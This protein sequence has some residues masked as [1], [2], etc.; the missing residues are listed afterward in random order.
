VLAIAGSAADRVSAEE[1]VRV[2]KGANEQIEKL[3]EK[4]L[5]VSCATNV[6]EANIEAI[7]AALINVFKVYD[8][9]L[10]TVSHTIPEEVRLAACEVF[11]SAAV[12]AMHNGGYYTYTSRAEN[13]KRVDTFSGFTTRAIHDAEALE[14]GGGDGGREKLSSPYNRWRSTVTSAADALFSLCNSDFGRAAALEAGAVPALVPILGDPDTE[15]VQIVQTVLAGFDTPGCQIIYM[16][17]TGCHQ[18]NV[19]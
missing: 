18:L 15:T 1:A 11:E 2:I 8:A 9:I 6:D 3:V 10:A 4:V 14:A 19:F 16:D 5:N 12:C 7:D 17:H 13:S